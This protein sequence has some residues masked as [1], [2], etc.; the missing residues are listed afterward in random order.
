MD[1]TSLYIM[2]RYKNISQRYVQNIDIWQIQKVHESRAQFLDGISERWP[3]LLYATTMINLVSPSNE[4][5]LNSHRFQPNCS[6]S[7]LTEMIFVN[8]PRLYPVLYSVELAQLHFEHGLLVNIR[9]FIH[10][11]F[12]SIQET[13]TEFGRRTFCSI[14]ISN[15][16][17]NC[18]ARVCKSLWSIRS[19][20]KFES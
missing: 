2:P 16:I 15:Y 20:R 12:I 6:I 1:Q 5:W 13:K 18:V 4:L 19:P 8:H 17:I 3:N 11:T 9:Q 10:L 7:S 14:L